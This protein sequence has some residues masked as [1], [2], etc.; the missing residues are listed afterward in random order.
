M[1]MYMHTCRALFASIRSDGVRARKIW[2]L[3]WKLADTYD[4]I[5]VQEAHGCAEDL[6]QMSLHLPGWKCYG[7]FCHSA[8]RGG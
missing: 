4:C 8:H 1:H 6:A 3:L 7:T 2:S 5:A